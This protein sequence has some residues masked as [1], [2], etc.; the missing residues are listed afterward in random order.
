[1]KL[2]A[3]PDSAF[4]T[5]PV[6]LKRTVLWP[7]WLGAAVWLVGAAAMAAPVNQDDVITP[8]AT[9]EPA[10]APSGASGFGALTAVGV[11]FLAGAG[12]WLLW[13]GKASKFAQLSRA[14][15]QLAVEETRSLGNRQYLVVATYQDRKFLLGV[16]PGRID[17]LAP[18][19]E[20]TPPVDHPRT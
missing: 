15:R 10:S 18:L 6:W 9:V 5:L 2:T 19:H 4:A 17:L 3:K 12:G 7:A 13:R 20:S 16:C 11:V 1:M 8:K 14:S